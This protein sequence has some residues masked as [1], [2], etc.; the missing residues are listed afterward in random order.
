MGCTH[1]H[2][3]SALV[4]KLDF[5]NAMISSTSTNSCYQVRVHLHDIEYG[6]K[7]MISSTKYQFMISSTNTNS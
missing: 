4:T 5:H 3:R 1:T 2:V 6:Y 7:V